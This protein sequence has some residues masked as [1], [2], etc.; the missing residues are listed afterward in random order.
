MIASIDKDLD[1]IPGWHYNWDKESKYYIDE[2]TGWR[3]FYK[4]IITGDSV[5]NIPGLDTWGPVK[6]ESLLS[7][8]HTK[9]EMEAAVLEKYVLAYGAKGRDRMQ[10]TGSLLWIQREEGVILRLGGE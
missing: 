7:F 10:E 9:E 6:A 2:E 1:M 3:N 4:Q 8:Y 5:D